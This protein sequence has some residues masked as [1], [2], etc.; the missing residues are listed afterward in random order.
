MPQR[1][2]LGHHTLLRQ[3]LLQL[4]QGQI[5]LGCDPVAQHLFAFRQPRPAMPADLKTA[6]Q[7]RLPL[8]VPHPID[9]EAA[10]LEPPSDRRRTIAA[11]QCRNTRSRKSCEYACIK[12]SSLPAGG[13]SHKTVYT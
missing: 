4:G 11:I 6:A 9:P 5:G 8:P 7:A 10:H 2:D 13:L 12:A 1:R 3:P